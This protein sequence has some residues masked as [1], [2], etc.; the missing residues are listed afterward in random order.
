ME[1]EVGSTATGTGNHLLAT[2]GVSLLQAAQAILQAEDGERPW[3]VALGERGL[4]RAFPS[5]PRCYHC[6]AFMPYPYAV[7]L[8][9]TLKSYPQCYAVAIKMTFI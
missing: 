9:T 8:F 6:T 1:Q 2:P 5:P 4:P 7:R 3:D